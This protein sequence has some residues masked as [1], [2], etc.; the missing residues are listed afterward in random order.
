MSKSLKKIIS[1]LI[2]RERERVRE[3][4]NEEYESE[5]HRSNVLDPRFRFLALEMLRDADNRTL[6]QGDIANSTAEVLQ[7][8]PTTTQK[9]LN[10]MCSSKGVLKKILKGRSIYIT[11]KSE[12]LLEELIEIN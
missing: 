5:I 12:E 6:P 8:S 7:C 3:S 11:F 9:Y 2:E 1:D 4:E 10:K